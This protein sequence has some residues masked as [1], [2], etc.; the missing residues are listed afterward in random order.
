M[1]SAATSL[2]MTDEAFFLSVSPKLYP[3]K[4]ASLA[5]RVYGSGP[6]LI[7]IHGFPT[8]GYTW[9][10]LLPTL[11]KYFTCYVLDLP[12]MGESDW[13]HSTDFSTSAQVERMITLFKQLELKEYAVLAHDTGAT[14]A[15]LLALLQPTAVRKLALINTE[16]PGHRPPWI[17]L[18]QKLAVLPGSA[19]LLPI[20]FRMKWYV[21]SGMGFREFYSD[22]RLLDRREYVGPY[23]QPLIKKAKRAQGALNYLRGFD[24]K[25][26]DEFGSRH[27]DLE[28]DIL[29]L[30]GA[31]D[32]TFPLAEA[33]K[34]MPQFKQAQLVPISKASLLPHEEKPQEI[35][36][37]LVPFLIK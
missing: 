3:I 33:E 12:G 34:M 30:W 25:I 35:I 15:R 9:R 10:K 24:W 2:S 5:I 31:D 36:E 37:H 7:L 23:L 6:A 26:V 16:V 11:S 32:K 13:D 4:D 27:K 17:P 22:K 21:K 19:A 20:P 28:M 29:F 18:Y 1:I 8:H 14:A